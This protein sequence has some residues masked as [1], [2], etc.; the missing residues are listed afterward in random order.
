[1]ARKT[2]Q[3]TDSL[4]SGFK[5]LYAHFSARR[6]RQ[7]TLV[8]A[9]MLVGA[10]AELATLGTVL[11]FLA[12]IA[13]PSRTTAYPQ[14]QGL[15]AVLGWTDPDRILIPATFLFVVV[16]LAAGAIRVL[17]VWASQKF[18]FRLG[19][20]LG[21][22][23]YRRTLYQPY[24]YHV[25][26]NTS[27]VIAGID[28]VQV[29]IFSMLL[30]LVLGVIAA[31]IS[32]FI[33]GALIAIDSSIALVAIAGFGVMYLGV[34][35]ATRR[36]LR[37]NSL[38]IANAQSRRIRTV[39][40]GL[41]GI[42]EVLINEAQPVY[43]DKFKRVDLA[44]RDAQAVNSFIGAAPRFAIEAWSMV[45]FACLALL[46]SGSPGGLG[47][48]LPI[49]G[50]LALGAQ[51]LL[52]SLQLVFSGWTH[53]AGNR[54]VLFDTLSILE[55]PI[56]ARHTLPENCTPMPFD[57]EI[58]L[59]GVS[60]RYGGNDAPALS[61]VNLTIERGARVGFIGKSGSGKSTITDLLMGL[62]EPTVGEIRIDGTPLTAANVRRWQ[63]QLAHVPQAIYLADTSIAENIALGVSQ[64]HIDWDCVQDAARRAALAEFVASLP[65]GY[66]TM[67]GERGIRLSGGQRQR[68]GIAR[69]FYRQA[70]VLV[71]DEA[72]SALDDETEAA[73]LEAIVNIERDITVL[74]IAHR[75]ST[76][77]M[78]DRII[79]LDAGRVVAESGSEALVV[80]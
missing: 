23:V 18:V 27:E 11:P 3:T 16:A 70:R 62:L 59:H 44:Y 45:L 77:A 73:V 22:D 58:S 75:L 64:Q 21:I 52:P 5:R 72:T 30:P 61:E 19:H 74:I 35:F 68:I 33:L 10:I 67:V 1:M 26:R 4:L 37:T 55:L 54:Q 24:P 8:M 78:C 66:R 79:R 41:G 15:F 6:R 56:H 42:R 69:A 2:Y 9:L 51:R 71:F 43:L 7:L 76:V 25:A 46:L 50:A 17:L 12:L 65:Q 47:A 60:F 63:V 14:L 57:R 28:K 39:Q 49:L 48:E 32:I 13:D 34:T 53:M 20:D 40:E 29:V 36:R 31:V 80:A 38:V